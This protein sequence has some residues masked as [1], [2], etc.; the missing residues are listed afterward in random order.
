VRVIEMPM[1]RLTAAKSWTRRHWRSLAVGA[2]A[3]YIVGPSCEISWKDEV[4]SVPA[5]AGKPGAVGV[6]CKAVQCNE[7]GT[8]EVPG[9]PGDYRFGLFTTHPALRLF[10]LRNTELVGFGTCEAPQTNCR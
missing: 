9:S 10:D 8:R 6:D 7:P 2:L 1:S 4:R 5:V 3:L